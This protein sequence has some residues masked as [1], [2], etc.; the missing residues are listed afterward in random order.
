M[1]FEIKVEDFLSQKLIM[2]SLNMYI[3][4]LSGAFGFGL[5]ALSFTKSHA[6]W[7]LENFS[8]NLNVIIELNS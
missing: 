3:I 2:T 7:K 1:E 6:F 8:I 4:Q 5:R